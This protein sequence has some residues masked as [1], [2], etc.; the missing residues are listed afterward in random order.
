MSTPRPPLDE[1][2]L[3]LIRTFLH[4]H[5]PSS[6]TIDTFDVERTAQRFIVNPNGPDT[7]TDRDA[8]RSSIIPIRASSRRARP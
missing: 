2:Q 3:D 7:H 5:F 8:R 4:T 6:E 1:R